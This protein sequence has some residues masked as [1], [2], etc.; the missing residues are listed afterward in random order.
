MAEQKFQLYAAT[1][2]GLEA[3]AGQE[4]RDLGYDVRVDN[5][6]IY[7]EGTMTDILRANI[8]LRSADRIKIILKTFSCICA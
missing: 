8:W 7:F 4:L 2:S 3:L 5:G 6:R 1:A